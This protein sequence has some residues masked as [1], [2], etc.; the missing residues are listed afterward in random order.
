MTALVVLTLLAAGLLLVAA[1]TFLREAN[2]YYASSAERFATSTYAL[3]A[4]GFGL[5][6]VGGGVGGW[7]AERAAGRVR[8]SATGAGGEPVFVGIA[9]ER[10]LDHWM[11]RIPHEEVTHVR[12][13]PFSYDSLRRSGTAAPR[14]P[15]DQRFWAASL[16]GRSTQTLEWEVEQGRWGVVVMNADARRGVRADVRVATLPRLVAPAAVVLLAGGLLL[17]AAA[18]TGLWLALREG[19]R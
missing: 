14:R 6:H 16:A 11:G 2:G 17:L 7:L 10:D 19:G 15:S 5:G 1:H 3:T 4:E 18:G 8:I 13:D 9:R 12:F